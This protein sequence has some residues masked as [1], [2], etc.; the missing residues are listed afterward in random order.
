MLQTKGKVFYHPIRFYFSNIQFLKNDL[1]A[2]IAPFSASPYY[3]TF[4]TE[5][6]LSDD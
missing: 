1:T 2:F 6:F 4:G 3:R 5:S